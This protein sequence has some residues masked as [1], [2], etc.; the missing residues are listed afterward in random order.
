MIQYFTLI[1]SSIS[2]SA[3]LTIF[4][5]NF[6]FFLNTSSASDVP[7]ESTG[8]KKLFNLIEPVSYFVDLPY[9][10]DRIN[11]HLKTYKRIT[12]CDLPG[13]GKTQILRNFVKKNRA[14]YDII[15]FFDCNLDLN[16]EFVRF[17]KRINE[18]ENATLVSED[19]RTAFTE[20]KEY[21]N[22]KKNWLLIFDNLKVGSCT[23]LRNILKWDSPEGH[24][25]FSSSELL[26]M[27]PNQIFPIKFSKSDAH[28]LASKI[29][30]EE[31]K[32]FA[33]FISNKFVKHPGS[34][35]L[36]ANVIN[37]SVG[38]SLEEY[39]KLINS[40]SDHIKFHIDLAKYTLSKKDIALLN[41]LSLIS[42]NFSRDFVNVISGENTLYSLLNLNKILVIDTINHT[43]E[44]II[45]EMNEIIA[46][47]I[48]KNN[49]NH[50]KKKILDAII[51]NVQT[52]RLNL[53]RQDQ[54]LFLNSPTVIDNLEI[55][56]DHAEHY[57]A[58]LYNI[59]FL[60]TYLLSMY[61]YTQN[62]HNASK[63]VEWF[64]E[65]NIQKI[66]SDKL[67][68]SYNE[69]SIFADYL[70]LAGIYNSTSLCKI[71]DAV[72]YFH[73]ALKTIGSSPKTTFELEIKALALFYLVESYS[74]IEN[75]SEAKIS[76]N[77]LE[78][79]YQ[80][81]EIILPNNGLIN[82]ARANLFFYKR[83]YK[84]ALSCVNLGLKAIMVS[85]GLQEYDLTNTYNHILR[86]K[87]L[88][89]LG[90]YQESYNELSKL[91]ASHKKKA[92]DHVIFGL[93]YIDMSR[94]QF[95]IGNI[96]SAESYIK[97]GIEILVHDD[98]RH[99][100]QLIENL[101]EVTDLDLSY[102]YELQ[103]DIMLKKKNLIESKKYYLLALD[104]YQNILADR[105]STSERYNTIKAKLDNL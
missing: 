42:T 3:F 63:M 71:N 78:K 22:R 21:L 68:K 9:Q 50:T 105:F 82:L 23:K 66:Y 39:T 91:Q 10:A 101:K 86:S 36:A 15:Y 58:N 53:E 56:L 62:F 19:I 87:I 80:N 37:N 48:K 38:L 64:Q 14:N 57:Q 47:S 75:F 8:K 70:L 43:P 93:I 92:K 44:N 76:L 100:S 34:I 96:D 79:I 61:L 67:W 11:S 16:A 33:D 90:K 81:Q 77:K 97:K 18:F 7:D 84:Q 28:L 55:L 4:Y 27:L 13:S 30:K 31:K 17:A 46:A 52:H 5:I 104:I 95:G 60:R 102:A 29:L 6:I 59:L 32:Q 72:K 35:V 69:K 1:C 2:K 88:N 65:K 54:Y 98:K 74:K 51:K 20:V 89:K 41:Q 73:K 103:G 12:L 99:K 45:Y 94:A 85:G 83:D 26:D 49:N 25:I 24:I 40:K